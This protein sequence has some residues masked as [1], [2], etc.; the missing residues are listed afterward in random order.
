MR[1]QSSVDGELRWVSRCIVSHSKKV[2]Y[3]NNLT[4][5]SLL[6]HLGLLRFLTTMM[7]VAHQFLFLNL[8]H[9]FEYTFMFFLTTKQIELR[10]LRHYLIELIGFFFIHALL[11]VDLFA[12]LRLSN[13][14]SIFHVFQLFRCERLWL[15]NSSTCCKACTMLNAALFVIILH[16]ISDRF[17]FIIWLVEILNR[18]LSDRGHL[19]RFISSLLTLSTWSWLHFCLLK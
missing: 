12:K 15:N 10:P 6:T 11:A 13:G 4:S 14:W 5:Y 1:L 16:T 19:N 9:F 18:F 3:L 7:I 17:S 8:S 2:V